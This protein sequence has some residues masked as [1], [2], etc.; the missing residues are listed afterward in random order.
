MHVADVRSEDP[1]QFGQAGVYGVR[2]PFHDGLDAAIGQIANVTAHRAPEGNLAG[3]HPKTHALNTAGEEDGPS[4]GAGFRHP[5]I[6]RA[7][8]G[9]RN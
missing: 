2:R 8:C 1:T 7:A 9:G 5:E 4:N 3:G 6:M